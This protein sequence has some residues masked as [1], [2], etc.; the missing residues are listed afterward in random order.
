VNERKEAKDK[1][2]KYD[3]ERGRTYINKQARL[4]H[5]EHI[6]SQEHI[7]FPTSI[8]KERFHT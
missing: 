5:I 4:H 3:M 6:F 1:E 8:Q 7:L 2:K